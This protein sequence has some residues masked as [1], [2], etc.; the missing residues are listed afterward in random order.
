MTYMSTYMYICRCM[1]KAGCHLDLRLPR[2]EQN[3]VVS[4]ANDIDRY[5]RWLPDHAILSQYNI[6]KQNAEKAASNYARKVVYIRTSPC[7]RKDHILGPHHE[8]AGTTIDG[9]L[10]G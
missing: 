8:S 4:M 1:R 5:K 2:A 7:L 9:F 10:P 6:M 3:L